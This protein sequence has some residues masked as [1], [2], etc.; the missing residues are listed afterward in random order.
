MLNLVIPNAR[1]EFLA[2][3]CSDH[4]PSHV[5]ID[6]PLKRPPRPFKFFYFWADHPDFYSIVED[7]WRETVE[8]NPLQVLFAKLKRLK[9]P[10]K[11]LN[12]ELYGDIH[13]R[14]LD[15]KRALDDVQRLVLSAPSVD[16]VAREK[17]LS[18]ELSALLGAEEKFLRQKSRVQ[19]IKDGDRNSAYFFSASCC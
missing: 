13:S 19:F 18:E 4:C 3:R 14:V 6:V 15:L 11:H 8:G 1:V 10:L 9:E 12:W 16:S 7:S 5:L 17:A 2:P